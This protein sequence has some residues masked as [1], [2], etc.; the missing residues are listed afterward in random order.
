MDSKMGAPAPWQRPIYGI[1]DAHAILAAVED[2]AGARVDERGVWVTIPHDPHEPGSDESRWHP[3]LELVEVGGD[4]PLSSPWLPF[5]FSAGQL[6]AFMLGGVGHHV[7]ERFGEWADGPDEHALALIDPLAQ[8]AR[9]ALV[10]A[11][12]AY[13]AVEE[14]NGS[15]NLTPFRLAKHAKLEYR[16]ANVEANRRQAVGEAGSEGEAY[17]SRRARAAESVEHLAAAAAAA[18][19]RA[20]AYGRAW[21]QKMVQE[22]WSG[23]T[24]TAPLKGR[25]LQPAQEDT[26]L[27]AIIRLRYDPRALPRGRNGRAGIKREVRVALHNFPSDAAFN[28]AWQRLLDNDRICYAP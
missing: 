25:L 26:I 27:E 14:R 28:K 2:L 10:E 13:R 18:Q 15:L 5:P 7:L 19:A 24:Q 16:E 21:R 11:F 23:S 9:R 17:S 22:L 3:L 12:Q 6:A 1:N 20:D 8:R 4:D